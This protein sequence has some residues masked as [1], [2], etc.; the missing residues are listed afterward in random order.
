VESLTHDLVFYDGHCGLCHGTVR[1]LSARDADGSRF[2]F[3]PL[4][5]EEIR[6]RIPEN[7][8]GS[9]PDSIVVL[10][11]AG[12]LLVRSDAV[13]HALGRVGGGWTVLAGVLRIVPRALRDPVYDL[14]A[15]VRKRLFR[16]PDDVC[17]I[18]PPELRGRFLA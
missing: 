15:R 6:R 18:L 1:F 11:T 12:R 9:L 16:R 14:V 10:D 7:E 17:P 8:R 2:R 13:L 5:G 3:A 4:Q